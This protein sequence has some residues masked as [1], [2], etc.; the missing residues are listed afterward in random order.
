MLE[1]PCGILREGR[2]ERLKLDA[3]SQRTIDN[4]MGARNETRG[5]ARQKCRHFGHLLWRAHTTG[6]VHTKSRLEKVRVADPD[7]APNTNG[8]VGVARQDGVSSDSF[9][10]QLMR[11]ASRVIE[12]QGPVF[13]AQGRDGPSTSSTESVVYTGCP[14]H[15]L[16]PQTPKT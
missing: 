9:T 13:W 8:K 10:C 6:R 1:I 4:E 16:S 3:P 15:R 11:T 14:P 5:R 12:D 7:L 2:A